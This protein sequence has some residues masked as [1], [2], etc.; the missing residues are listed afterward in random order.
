[1]VANTDVVT[2]R[3]GTPWS[4]VERGTIDRTCT[5]VRTWRWPCG[6]HGEI[7]AGSLIDLTWCD[8]HS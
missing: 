3:L 2:L 1:M 6:C 8:L 7:I 4:T 5:Y